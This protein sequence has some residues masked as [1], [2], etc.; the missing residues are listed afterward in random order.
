MQKR[1]WG[2]LVEL[3]PV[4]EGRPPSLG[5]GTWK[6]HAEDGLAHEIWPDKLRLNVYTLVINKYSNCTL[7]TGDNA[8][9]SKREILYFFFVSCPET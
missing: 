9:P 4:E 2:K 3:G 6:I 5:R 8:G 1:V 7:I